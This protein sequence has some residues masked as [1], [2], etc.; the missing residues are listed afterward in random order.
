[1]TN[2]AATRCPA[3]SCPAELAPPPPPWRAS[4][5]GLTLSGVQVSG[6]S[7]LLGPLLP[8]PTP[9]YMNHLKQPG[10]PGPQAITPEVLMSFVLASCHRYRG[11]THT[12]RGPTRLYIVSLLPRW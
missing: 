3:Q 5:D 1:M 4:Q 11:L 6:T 12:P 2:H 7:G 9:L 8:D 10:Q